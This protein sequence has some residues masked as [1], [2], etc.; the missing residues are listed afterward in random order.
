MNGG[1]VMANDTDMKRAF[2]LTHQARRLN[3]PSLLIVNNDAR[4]LPNLKINDKQNNLKF[5]R[6]LCDVPCSGDGT[7]RKNLGLWRNFHNHMGHANHPLQLDI[8]ERGLK[9]LKLGGRLVYSTCTFNPIEDEAVV[10][11]AVHRH[12]KQVKLVDVSKEISPHL[13]FRPGMLNW[14]VYHRGKGKNHPAEFYKNFQTVPEFRKK[15]IKETMFT[16]AYTDY[17]NDEDRVGQEPVDPLNLRHCMRFYPHDD[18]QGGFFVAVFEKILDEEDGIIYDDSYSMDAWSNPKI[19]QKDI[20]DDLEDF[21][22]DFEKA[23]KDQ[24]ELTGEKDDGDE[25]Q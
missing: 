7:F 19:R 12:I 6:I 24:E 25:L 11:A 5:D 1:F 13:K 10:A 20:I 15:V 18:N 21:V 23:I 3:S 2:M 16:D 17:N 22:N 8:L 9:L 14:K 4:F